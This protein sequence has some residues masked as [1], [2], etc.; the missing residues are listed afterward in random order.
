VGW[1]RSRKWVREKVL[2]ETER[3]STNRGRESRMECRGH[4]D[5]A[6]LTTD[7]QLYIPWCRTVRIL[8]PLFDMVFDLLIKMQQCCRCSD[9]RNLSSIH[10]SEQNPAT[11]SY[12]STSQTSSHISSSAMVWVLFPPIASSGCLVCYYER[13]FGSTAI[14]IVVI[15]LNGRWEYD[16]R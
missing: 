5:T 14:K 7:V 6:M 10:H 4:V 16:W 13:D 2:P 12:L 15:A 9:L 8:G 11:F 1:R 3:A